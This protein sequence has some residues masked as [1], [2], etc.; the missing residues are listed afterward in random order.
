M[1]PFLLYLL[2]AAICLIPFYALYIFILRRFTFFRWNRFYLLLSLGLSMI[3]PLLPAM[4]TQNIHNA[5]L[6]TAIATVAPQPIPVM[7]QAPVVIKSSVPV[8]NWWN[9]AAIIY[10]IGAAFM[11]FI[12]IRS[13]WKIGRII[14]KYPHLNKENL[15]LVLSDDEIPNASFFSY[16]FIQK[17]KLQENDMAQILAHES[18]HERKLH[19]LDVL[20]LEIIK[21][22]WWFNPMIYL[23]KKSLQEA[24]EFEVDREVCLQYNKK[25]YAELLLRL[26]KPLTLAPANMFSLHPLKD[27]VKMLFFKDSHSW[28]KWLYLLVLPLILVACE[29]LG[30]NMMAVKPEPGILTITPNH[31]MVIIDSATSLKSIQRAA[32]TLKKKRNIDLKVLQYHTDK[33]GK[34]TQLKLFFKTKS[35]EGSGTWNFD[36]PHFWQYYRPVLSSYII[37]PNGKPSMSIGSKL[38]IKGRA[39]IKD[40]VFE[41]FPQMKRGKTLFQTNCASCHNPVKDMT[42]PAL[43]GIENRHSK[44]WIYDFVHNSAALIANG[45]SDAIRIY[46][47]WN[48]IPMTRFPNLPEKD[49]DDILTYIKSYQVI[50]RSY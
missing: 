5:T 11:F 2:K 16:V 12:F 21:V 19:S 24:H 10:L 7:P 6:G 29:Q 8:L 13:L 14:Y 4:L 15:T 17:N 23:Y 18:C 39:H 30:H 44:E 25:N 38:T 20:L 50:N 49:I 34:I 46:H 43:A 36:E 22:I 28:K 27:R 45:D 41:K 32:D 42:G 3:I 33:T 37:A 1:T 47:Q 40:L 26:S 48:E 31:V 9:L 35:G